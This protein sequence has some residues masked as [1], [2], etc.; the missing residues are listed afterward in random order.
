[1][2]HKRHGDLDTRLLLLANADHSKR[3]HRSEP[4]A[5]STRPVPNLGFVLVGGTTGGC[6]M[7][8]NE[9]LRRPSEPDSS[10]KGRFSI[11][12]DAACASGPSSS[13]S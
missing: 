1:M 7:Y 4:A 11:G 6:A 5:A 12:V 13:A 9:G 3:Q 8:E 10:G 2:W